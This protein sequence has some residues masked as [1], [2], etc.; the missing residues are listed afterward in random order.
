MLAMVLER[1][2]VEAE[3]RKKARKQGMI[4][5]V[6]MESRLDYGAG[7]ASSPADYS[8]KRAKM[9]FLLRVHLP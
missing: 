5:M 3:G 9:G 8:S 2:D 6:G 1:V 4:F 7:K